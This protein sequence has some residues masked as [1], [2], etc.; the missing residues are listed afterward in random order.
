MSSSPVNNDNSPFRDLKFKWKDLQQTSE[1]RPCLIYQ[2]AQLSSPSTVHFI[3]FRN[4][5]C[6]SIK[7]WHKDAKKHEDDNWTFVCEKKLMKNCHYENDAQCYFTIDIAKENKDIDLDNI[8]LLRFE[9]I[10]PSPNWRTIGI[11][12]LRL[13]QRNRDL[14]I[15][16]RVARKDRSVDKDSRIQLISDNLLSTLTKLK[17]YN[18]V[19]GSYKEKPSLYG[20]ILASKPYD[21]P[22]DKD[23]IVSLT[24]NTDN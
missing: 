20:Q 19:L 15:R 6:S 16:D 14:Q 4:Y 3:Q 2:E 24:C 7:I 11:R 5:Y 8:Y 21:V 22:H 9:Y 13:I 1:K 23:I 17:Q 12:N 18:E 10:Q